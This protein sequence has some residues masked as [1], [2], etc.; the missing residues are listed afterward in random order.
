[1]DSIKELSPESLTQLL[2]MLLRDSY[3][4]KQELKALIHNSDQRLLGY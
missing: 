4:Q 2:G 3:K 1:M